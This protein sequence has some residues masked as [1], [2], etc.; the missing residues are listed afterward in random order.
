[1]NTD[2]SVVVRKSEDYI[3]S[4]IEIAGGRYAFKNLKNV[5][6]NAPSVKLTMEEF[7]ATAV[8]ADYLIYNGTIDGAGEEYQRPGS[9]EQ[10]VF[11][12]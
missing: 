9:E 10:F 1:M 4:M 2:G 7:Y 6:S 8:D 3:P 11:R 12:I 5:D